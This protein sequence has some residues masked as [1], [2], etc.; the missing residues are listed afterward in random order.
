MI[1]QDKILEV[2]NA[3][4]IVDVIGEFFPLQKAGQGRFKALCPFHREKTPS[5]FVDSSRQYFKCFGCGKGGNV[6]SFLMEKE[7]MTFPE[8]V[9][10]LASRAGINLPRSSSSGTGEN[11][12]NY[13]EVLEKASTFFN[14]VLFE[15]P[16]GAAALEYLDGRSIS[17]K[18]ARDFKLGFSPDSWDSLL[19][20]MRSSGADPKVLEK[21]GLARPRKES[22][23]HYDYFRGRLMFPIFDSRGRTVGFGARSMDGSEPKYL[24]SPETA[25]FQKSRLLY[26]LNLARHAIMD[27]GEV[28]V[29][30]GYTDV[31][32]CHEAGFN[33][34]VA[35]LGTAF[36]ESHARNL[37]RYAERVVLLYDADAAGQKAADASLEFLAGAGM[38]V[39]VVTLPGGKDPC[40][41]IVDEGPGRFGEELE[42]G[43]DVF[44]F[45]YDRLTSTENLTRD[46]VIEGMLDMAG[47][48][49]DPI[50]LSDFLSRLET[51]M[52]VPRHLL[53]EKLSKMRK[54]GRRPIREKSPEK[55]GNKPIDINVLV[56]DPEWSLLELI[57]AEEE[58]RA[59]AEIVS[60]IFAEWPPDKFEHP[61]LGGLLTAACALV[62]QKGEFTPSELFSF[63]DEVGSI[64]VAERMLGCRPRTPEQTEK[65][66]AEALARLE[67]KALEKEIRIVKE[68][69]KKAE[70]EGN[71]KKASELY[72]R[73]SQLMKKR[74]R[75]TN[76]RGVG[77]GVN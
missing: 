2:Q 23:G 34:A 8:A 35:T 22:T 77:G 17:R 46:K 6:F 38:D 3:V 76:V 70:V 27:K 50:R 13:Y 39:K 75:H 66:I 5:F 21:L 33:N 20:H 12:T 73:Y 53:Q 60:R 55:K 71:S 18:A 54:T 37:K 19:T 57:F 26:G 72:I 74:N 58:D 43:R 61:E 1:P 68:A 4:D 25:V 15:K 41:F 31:I 69:G 59:R 40:E 9:E 63:L 64:S 14:N 51:R 45:K 36:G 42:K 47:S 52:G 16:E 28:V 32:K 67:I 44:D 30:E 7:R 24:N 29:C 10:T 49:S 65:E 48:I 62:E 11:T 56:R